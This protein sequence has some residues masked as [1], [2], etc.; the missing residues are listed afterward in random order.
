MKIKFEQAAKSQPISKKLTEFGECWEWTGAR[1]YQGYG[2][3]ENSPWRFSH[4]M[5]YH[6]EHRGLSEKL[7]I[8]HL[9]RNRSCCNPAH[10]EAVTHAENTLRGIGPT[11]I[12]AK[13]THCAKGHEFTSDNTIFRNGG[14]RRCRACNNA[15]VCRKKSA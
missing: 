15:N 6:I 1:D 7:E 4:R 9:C 3:V 14:G 13:K 11:A 2:I 10:L 5:F 12:N 8:D